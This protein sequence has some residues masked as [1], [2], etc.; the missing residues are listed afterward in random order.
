[1]F[2][3]KMSLPRRTFLRGVGATLGLPLLDAM[4]PAA[5][6]LAQTAARPPRRFAA[7]YSPNGMIMSHWTP[8]ASGTGFDLPLILKPLEAFRDQLVVVSGLN[9]GPQREGGHA[10]AQPC[11]L[12]GIL[13]PKQ[14]EGYDLE[15][16]TTIDQALAAQ[17]G[18]DTL[19][20]SL[21]ITAEDFTTQ[22]GSCE[23][24]FSCAYLN[25]ISWRTPTQP[26]PMEL[27]P[28]LVFER[29]FGGGLGSPRAARRAAAQPP[30]RARHGGRRGPAAAGPSDAR[31]PRPDGRL[32]AEHPRDRAAPRAHRAAERRVGRRAPTRRSA[33]PTTTRITSA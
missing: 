23:V 26:L 7:A 1:M 8:A 29:M 27:N 24:G 30:E 31:R 13:H 9:A 10:L 21:E 4:V 32:P 16:A 6:A 14:T 11:W 15:A 5:T 17:Y 12:T 25:T 3:T 20:R 18:T 2:L 22:V 33:C 28:R 19:F